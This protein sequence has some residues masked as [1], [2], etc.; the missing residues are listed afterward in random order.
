MIHSALAPSQAWIVETCRALGFGVIEGLSIR[1]G[2]PC[3]EPEPRIIQ[4]LKLDSE[5]ERR[6]CGGPPE[7][8]PKMQFARVFDELSRLG[9]ATVDIE[10]RHGLPFRLV[11]DRTKEMLQ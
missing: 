8:T 1:G 11:I 4:T 3:F 10:F 9:D 5:G 2:L 6:S 7:G